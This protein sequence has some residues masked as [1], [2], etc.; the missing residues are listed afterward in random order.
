MNFQKIFICKLLIASLIISSCNNNSGNKNPEKTPSESTELTPGGR[1]IEQY[2]D[3]VLVEKGM[4]VDGKKAGLWTYWY[5]N[6]EKKAEGNYEDGVKDG[7]WVQWYKDGSLMWKGVCENGVRKL[8]PV[9]GEARITAIGSSQ[10]IEYMTLDSV[11]HLQIRITNIPAD[12]LFVEAENATIKKENEPDQFS[13]VPESGNTVKII[14][15]YYPDPAFKDFRNLVGEY[16]YS[17]K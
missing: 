8:S 6:G 7:I 17:I 15:G 12:Y 13:C 1:L 11:Y 5:E 9:V 16:E 14:I 2:T 10:D 4:E 3:S